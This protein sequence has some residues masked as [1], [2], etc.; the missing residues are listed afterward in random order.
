M[1]RHDFFFPPGTHAYLVNR[2]SRHIVRPIMAPTKYFLYSSS[3]L[4]NRFWRKCNCCLDYVHRQ[5]SSTNPGGM[6]LHT[7]VRESASTPSSRDSVL[8]PCAVR[9]MLLL[10]LFIGVIK[11]IEFFLAV[12]LQPGMRINHLCS[13]SLLK[14]HGI[15]LNV[16]KSNKLIQKHIA[17]TRENE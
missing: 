15:A 17:A 10:I 3:T 7:E 2:H 4:P 14:L 8:L 5:H 13:E 12:F 16:S 1:T 6:T 9:F 11:R